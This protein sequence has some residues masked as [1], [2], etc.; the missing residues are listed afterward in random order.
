MRARPKKHR[1]SLR[2]PTHCTN[3]RSPPML[4]LQ[5][6]SPR[7]LLLLTVSFC[8]RHRFFS[9]PPTLSPRSS[10]RRIGYADPSR[11]HQS[12]VPKLPS[13]HSPVGSRCADDSINAFR[14]TESSIVWLP[15]PTNA[16]YNPNPL[17]FPLDHFSDLI[18]SLVSLRSCS[19]WPNS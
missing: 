2:P 4:L 8:H 17:R 16:P 3:C 12:I 11:M 15:P 19:L 1:R 7:Q 6:N 10:H 13:V 14:L 5:A 18:Y 9:P